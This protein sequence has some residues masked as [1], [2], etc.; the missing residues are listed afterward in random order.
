M[1]GGEGGRKG[2]VCG[3]VGWVYS[4]ATGVHGGG[5]GLAVSLQTSAAAIA[6]AWAGRLVLGERERGREGGREGGDGERG[7]GGEEVWRK[8]RGK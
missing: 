7:G 2:G 3:G 8:E 5:G 4:A 1:G 6:S